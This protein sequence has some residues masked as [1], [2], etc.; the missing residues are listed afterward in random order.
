MNVGCRWDECVSAACL[1]A[2][3]WTSCQVGNRG[4]GQRAMVRAGVLGGQRGC[5]GLEGGAN[6]HVLMQ[7]VNV[8]VC[9]Q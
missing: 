2:S 8:C 7:L 5:A 9:L 1:Q 3:S 4:V 6:V